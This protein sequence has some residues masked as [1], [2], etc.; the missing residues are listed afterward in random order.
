MIYHNDNLAICFLH[1]CF[2]GPFAGFIGT[3]AAAIR[4]Q[5]YCLFPDPSKR[6]IDGYVA[7]TTCEWTK[8]R[9]M[10]LLNDT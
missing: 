9:T 4:Q 3:I 10:L 2:G 8:G 7:L 6:D 5:R 1:G